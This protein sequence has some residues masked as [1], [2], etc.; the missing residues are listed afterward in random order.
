MNFRLFGL[1]YLFCLLMMISSDLYALEFGCSL[2]PSELAQ[3]G[4]RILKKVHSVGKSFPDDLNLSTHLYARIH[5]AEE[6]KNS[7]VSS[8]VEGFYRTIRDEGYVYFA[9]PILRFELTREHSV[10]YLCAHADSDPQKTHITIYFLNGYGLDP[11]GWRSGWGDLLH[12]TQM[13]LSPIEV[14]LIAVG[15]DDWLLFPF[16]ES[17]PILGRVTS[18]PT[19]ILEELNLA[20]G[21]FL[22]RPFGARVQ[23]II[24]TPEYLQLDSDVDVKHPDQ[25]TVFFRF[26]FGTGV[27][28]TLK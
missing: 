21:E 28:E 19:G 12:P 9:I 17:I 4:T 25:A 8:T 20:L 27:A 3:V 7:Q 23:R 13:K 2:M 6:Q 26:N 10:V 1:R 22:T 24:L 14:S 16:L 5:S 11:L 18:I 15:F